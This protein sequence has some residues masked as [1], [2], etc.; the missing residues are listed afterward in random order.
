MGQPRPQMIA[1]SVQKNLGLVFHSAKRARMNDPRPVALKFSAKGVT[2]LRIL[3]PT[4]IGRLLRKRRQG[5]LLR[6]FHLLTRSP[7]ILHAFASFIERWTLRFSFRDCPAKPALSCALPVSPAA[8]RKT[9]A[10]AQSWC[11]SRTRSNTTKNQADAHA[12]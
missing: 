9:P 5:R 4:R 6:G 2:R 3:A 8:H 7:R 1:G 10:I 12:G 11:A